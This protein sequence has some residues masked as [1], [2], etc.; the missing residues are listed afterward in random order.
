MRPLDETGGAGSPTE[1]FDAERYV[2]SIWAPKVLQG[3]VAG[4]RDVD[5]AASAPAFFKGSGKVMKVDTASRAGVALVDLAPGDGKADV[6]LQVGPV[7][8]G[9]ALR[10][11]LGLGF[12]DFDSQIDYANVAGKLNE[13]AVAGLASL[14][15]PAA[16]EGKTVSFAGAGAVNVDGL[17][18]LLPVTLEIAP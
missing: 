6:A 8:R 3:G 12:S 9:T 2:Q 18:D 17:L 11:A 5:L 16:L 4:A 7:T 15:E 14:K 10:D 1:R 13:R